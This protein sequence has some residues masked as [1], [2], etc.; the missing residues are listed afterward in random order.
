MVGNAFSA[1]TPI[2]PEKMGSATVNVCVL[3]RLDE[4]AFCTVKF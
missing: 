3:E 4:I 2:N 1:Q